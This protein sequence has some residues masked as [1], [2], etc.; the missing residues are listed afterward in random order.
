MQF[1][2]ME[3]DQRIISI[4][5]GGSIV[6]PDKIDTAYLKT[7]I[8]ALNELST[9]GYKFAVTIGGGKTVRTYQQAAKEFGE[10]PTNFGD[11]IGLKQVQMHAHWLH[12]ICSIGFSGKLYPKVIFEEDTID[13]SNYDLVIVTGN[14]IGHTTDF[15]AASF[16]KNH[17]TRLLNLS[18]I[19]Y[20]YTKDPKL[21][22]A[23]PLPTLR[24]EE[25][26]TI[27]DPKDYEAGMHAPFDP[28]AAKLCS[29]NGLAV[30]ITDGRDIAN[31]KL[32]IK[33]EGKFTRI[34]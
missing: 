16:A 9:E 22:G 32:V 6:I 28:V 27:F 18:N 5:L 10:L 3:Q 19:Y 7:F 33:G 12:A 2:L 1:R 14:A 31:L 13:M 24:W 23:E 30:E 20:V 26:F 8:D 15:D 4:S 17:Q 21:D 29:D 11:I 25:Y 34:A